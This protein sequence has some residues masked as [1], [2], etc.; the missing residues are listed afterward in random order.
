MRKERGGSHMKRFGLLI[1]C[2]VC[3]CLS[4]H[5]ED[6]VL[7]TSPLAV[8]FGSQPDLR[9]LHISPDGSKL[10]FI[11]FHPEG[12]D[13]VSTW[14]SRTKQ[15]RIIFSGKKDSYEVNW[16]RW[17]NEER[18]LCGLSA[19]S[20]IQG[21]I[22]PTARLAAVNAD[23]KDI[24]LLIPRDFKG[25][26]GKNAGNLIDLK[27]DDPEHVLVQIT[28]FG[29]TGVGTLDIYHSRLGMVAANT[30]NAV[31]WLTD[32]HGELRLRLLFNTKRKP[33]WE[34]QNEGSVEWNEF[35]E[36]EDRTDSLLPV[37]F[38]DN[39]NTLM[40]L[41]NYQ[42]RR[43]LYAMDLSANAEKHL[44]F[45]NDH[46]DVLSMQTIGKYNR[47]VA[48][49]YMDKK[50]QHYY[51][52]KDLQQLQ[53]NIATA[54]PNQSIDILDEDW[55]RRH[56][57][58]F[59]HGDT[60]PG[61]YYRYDRTNKKLTPIGYI[62]AKL[63]DQKLSPATKITYRAKD[64]AVI[65]AF[66]TL[67]SDGKKTGLPAV[68]LPQGSQNTVNTWGFDVL[69]QF[70]AANGYAVLQSNYRGSVG[71]G[72]E[73]QGLGPFGE[74][75]KAVSD[76][77]DGAQ[78]LINEGIADPDRIC[79]AGWDYGGYMALM[80]SI[81]NPSLYKCVVSIAGVSEP[82]DLRSAAA[83]IAGGNS[84][85][86]NFGNAEA[87]DESSPLDRVGEIKVP[88]FLA[89]GKE[90]YNVP[91]SQSEDLSIA[92]KKQLKLVQFIQYDHAEHDIRP[93]RYRIDLFTRVAEFLNKYTGK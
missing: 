61:I 27:A 43:A 53:S 48:A 74:W 69:V 29:G 3:L 7:K 49:V 82:A 19:I 5:A 92:L 76:I 39:P 11:Q 55:N 1:I 72:K 60:K 64:N 80:S 33:Q 21:N 89:H 13:V 58:V 32:G 12:I 51:F 40:V 6:G 28:D 22:V 68:I 25:K 34:I 63:K 15:G 73:W 26:P 20:T 84:A 52:D 71:Y 78:Y 18:V 54:F 79:V 4:V 36:G 59:I 2:L 91:F 10:V 87:T 23:G 17:A 56:Y 57:I 93:P 47:G 45:A 9:S 38:G 35:H 24:K 90:D 62:S 41:D 14:D 86:V 37:G 8:K 16:C 83:G 70:L 30:K 77:A 65:P 42:G 46:V 67:P 66:L 85:Q 44:V 81:E 88:V 50:L 75:R 31:A